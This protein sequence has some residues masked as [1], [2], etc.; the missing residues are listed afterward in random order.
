VYFTSPYTDHSWLMNFVFFLTGFKIFSG[1]ACAL[2]FHQLN[3]MDTRLKSI[4]SELKSIKSES[5]RDRS[6][7]LDTVYCAM[8]SYEGDKTHMKEWMKEYE[9]CKR[10]DSEFDIKRRR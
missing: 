8:K 1:V 9:Y 10:Y 7:F 4:D 3:A 5:D 6:I 2:F